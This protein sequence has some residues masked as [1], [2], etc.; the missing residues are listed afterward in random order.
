M[1]LRLS[2]C[3]GHI[4]ENWLLMQDSCDLWQARQKVALSEVETL[5]IVG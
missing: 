1:A 2:K 5:A 4:P 3:L